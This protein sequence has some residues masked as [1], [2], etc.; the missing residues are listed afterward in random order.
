MKICWENQVWPFYLHPHTS[1]V[2]QPLDLSCFAFVKGRYRQEVAD[3]AR[4]D[5]SMPI[6]KLRFVQFYENARNS[7]LSRDHIIAGWKASGVH[8]WRPSKVL[9][10]TQVV[11]TQPTTLSK[12]LPTPKRARNINI[13]TPTNT[14]QLQAQVTTILRGNHDDRTIRLL[15]AKAGK[16]MTTL[17]FENAKQGLLLAKQNKLVEEQRVSKRRRVAIDANDTFA[18]IESIIAAQQQLEA[19]KARWEHLDRLKEARDS[20]NLLIQAGMEAFLLE[21]HASDLI[22][23]QEED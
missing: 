7:G 2:C 3:L 22:V 6:K 21:W 10:S 5:D 11:P 9:R 14:K 18:D 8:P 15:F 20:S 17:Q 23:A 19:Q 12:P 4:F 13:T 1:H 16:T